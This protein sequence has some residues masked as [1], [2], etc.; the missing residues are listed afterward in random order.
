MHPHFVSTVRKLQRGLTHLQMNRVA[1]STQ[2]RY[3]ATIESLFRRL[4]VKTLPQWDCETWDEVLS[5]Q[6]EILHDHKAAM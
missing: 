6:L 1:P 4:C 2:R 3:F 5:E